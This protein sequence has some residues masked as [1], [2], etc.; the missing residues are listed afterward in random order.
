MLTVCESKGVRALLLTFSISYY[1]LTSA[2]ESSKNL[3]ISLCIK[4]SCQAFITQPI[5]NLKTTLYLLQN[6]KTPDF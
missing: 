2:S 3:A 6:Q 1:I 4:P 5:N